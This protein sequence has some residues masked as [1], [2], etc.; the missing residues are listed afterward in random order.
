MEEGNKRKRT[1]RKDSREQRKRHTRFERLTHQIQQ[2]NPIAL[3]TQEHELLTQ[4]LLKIFSPS[5]V[6]VL[7]AFRERRPDEFETRFGIAS[8]EPVVLESVA[9]TYLRQHCNRYLNFL[10]RFRT[11]LLRDH[12]F[13]ERTVLDVFIYKRIDKEVINRVLSATFFSLSADV[14]TVTPE[15]TPTTEPVP[16][17]S[18]AIHAIQTPPAI[19]PHTPTLQVVS[20]PTSTP[21]STPTPTPTPMPTPTPTPTVAPMPTSTPTPSST[22]APASISTTTTTTTSLQPTASTLPSSSTTA[23]TKPKIPS[24]LVRPQ[25]SNQHH[26]HDKQRRH[27]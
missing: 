8:N 1:D 4:W 15:P 21:A 7:Q 19:S 5:L 18:T 13:L 12:S 10:I 16:T 11:P 9:D 17:N 20:P 23:F 3:A 25:H 24:V 26:R 2:S 22:H 27:Q 6:H 14:L